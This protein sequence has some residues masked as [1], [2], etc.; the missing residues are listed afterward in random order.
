MVSRR[1]ALIALAVVVCLIFSTLPAFAATSLS[2][3]PN[4]VVV[5]PTKNAVMKTG[6]VLVSVKMTAPRTIRMSLYEETKSGRSL[7]RTEKYS[8]SRSLSY[9]TRQLTGLD[10]GVYCVNISTLNSA[11]S[12]IYASE[13]YVKVQ[14]RTSDTVKVDVFN[15]QNSLSSFWATLLKKLLG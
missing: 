13:I 4:I 10:P 3:D 11:G 1:K 2:K 7:I 5:S 8:S 15:S 9:Y 14:K 6:T 12:A